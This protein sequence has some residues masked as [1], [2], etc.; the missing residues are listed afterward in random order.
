MERPKSAKIFPF[1]AYVSDDWSE[2]SYAASTTKAF[3]SPVEGFVTMVV[4]PTTETQT[5]LPLLD[6]L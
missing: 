1:V 6:S 3:W 2:E 4:S 5:L